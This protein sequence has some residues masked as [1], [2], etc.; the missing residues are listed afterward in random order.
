MDSLGASLMDSLGASLAHTYFW[1]Q[2][3]SHWI[4]FYLFC[5]EVGGVHYNADA[6]KKLE[7]MSDLASSC[8][9]IYFYE[10]VCFV[11]GRPKLKT[12]IED[13]NGRPKHILHCA[14]GPRCRLLMAGLCMPGGAL[15]FR[16][17]T[18]T[19]QLRRPES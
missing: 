17:N 1:G 6:K 5:S 14:D 12:I 8:G 4:A 13:R 18:I 16:S 9:W 11:S 2:H 15:G 10:N 7:I 19:N 3:D